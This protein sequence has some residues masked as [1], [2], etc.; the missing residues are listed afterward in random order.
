MHMNIAA[1][2]YC[3]VWIGVINRFMGCQFDSQDATGR[4][5]R[6]L[7]QSC[8]ITRLDVQSG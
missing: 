6:S 4:D 7:L 1:A 3:I 5:V 2:N 8:E